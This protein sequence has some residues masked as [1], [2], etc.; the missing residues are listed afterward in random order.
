MSNPHLFQSGLNHITGAAVMKDVRK[1]SSHTTNV[2]QSVLYVSIIGTNFVCGAV[3]MH[4][5][6]TIV[7][8]EQTDYN[9]NY[10]RCDDRCDATTPTCITPN[11][12][13]IHGL[14]LH[15]CDSHKGELWI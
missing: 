6:E 15:T 2:L 12:S 1:V 5:R 14:I 8:N 13:T 3:Y 4:V 9:E 10:S 7:H 11:L